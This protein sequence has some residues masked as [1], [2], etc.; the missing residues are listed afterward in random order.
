MWGFDWPTLLAAFAVGTIAVARLT[1][2]VVDDDF[3]PIVWFRKVW[4]RAL[5][6]SSW[7][8]LIEC[9]FCTAPYFAA[10]SIGWAT[11][12]H[13]HWSWWLF[14]GWLAVSYLAAMVNT[15]DIPADQR[16]HH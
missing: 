5:N 6:G 8:T 4:D 9:P 3:P 10:F 7:S 12:T 2:L 15:R 11:L 13:L 1:R 16:G 14:H